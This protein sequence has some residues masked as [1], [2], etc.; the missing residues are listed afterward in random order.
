MIATISRPRIAEVLGVHRSTV[1]KYD[2]PEPD[3]A[4]TGAGGRVTYSWREETII[5]WAQQ[6]QV[7]KYAQPER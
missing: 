5:D 1:T 2:L 3:V 4:M 6:H 7:G